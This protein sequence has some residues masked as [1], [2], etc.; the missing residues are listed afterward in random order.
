MNSFDPK[1]INYDILK[2]RA[3]VYSTL[4]GNTVCDNKP[5]FIIEVSLW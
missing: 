5:S 1:N 3:L 4:P 2:C